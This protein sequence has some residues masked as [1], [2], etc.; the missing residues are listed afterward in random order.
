[1]YLQNS[2]KATRIKNALSACYM[3]LIMLLL[4]SC[5]ADLGEFSE[6]KDYYESFGDIDVYNQGFGYDSYDM[7][8][9]YNDDMMEHFTDV[10]EFDEYTCFVIEIDKKIHLDSIGMFFLLEGNNSSVKET[11]KF[12]Y[13][14]FWASDLGYIDTLKNMSTYD[15]FYGTYTAKDH[16]FKCNGLGT[17]TVTI[18]N[19]EP[20][21]IEYTTGYNDGSYYMEFD[22]KMSET[23]TDRYYIALENGE[24]MVY[25]NLFPTSEKYKYIEFLDDVYVL[26]R[27]TITINNID[28]SSAETKT[29]YDEN[30]NEV[31]R[32]DIDEGD[33]LIITIDN[34]IY[35]HEKKNLEKV[36]FKMNGLMI[37]SSSKD[38]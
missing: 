5:A 22:Y 23:Q 25:R 13:T 15:L 19:N 30:K 26:F 38:V 7:E 8:D 31:P 18:G 4:T 20:R 6:K 2:G 16:I 10:M 27:E 21:A 3:L 12:N 37:R 24:M 35:G 29:F 14:C 9:L 36:K 34:N 32:V 28:Y 1:M 11:K 17:V 33:Y